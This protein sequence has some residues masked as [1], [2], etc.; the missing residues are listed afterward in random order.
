MKRLFSYFACILILLLLATSGCKKMDTNEELV[1]VEETIYEALDKEDK[2]LNKIE[3]ITEIEYME[4]DYFK[5]HFENYPEGVQENLYIIKST[6]VIKLLNILK[7][8]QFELVDKDEANDLSS[9]INIQFIRESATSLEVDIHGVSDYFLDGNKHIVNVDELKQLL[10]LFNLD[11]ILVYEKKTPKSLKDNEIYNLVVDGILGE[12]TD[13]SS[14]EEKNYYDYEIE[15]WHSEIMDTTEIALDIADYKHI[16]VLR[17]NIDQLIKYLAT[18]KEYLYAVEKNQDT[19]YLFYNKEN[20]LYYDSVIMNENYPFDEEN[21]SFTL[22]ETNKLGYKNAR[23]YKDFNNVA[24]HYQNN[25]KWFLDI[26]DRDLFRLDTIEVP[27]NYELVSLA[28]K[29]IQGTFYYSITGYLDGL[30]T[31]YIPC[32]YTNYASDYI[33]MSFIDVQD[34]QYKLFKNGIE[35]SGQ[36]LYPDNGMT[37]TSY[38]LV[39][40]KGFIRYSNNKSIASFVFETETNKQLA[41]VSNWKQIGNLI[42]FSEENYEKTILNNKGE[43]LENHPLTNKNIVLKS[44][45]LDS[46]GHWNFLDGFSQEIVQLGQD[47]EEMNRI[48]IPNEYL[49]IKKYF[50]ENINRYFEPLENGF[51]LLGDDVMI[52]YSYITDEFINIPINIRDNVRLH[53]GAV[54][55]MDGRT[56]KFNEE[57]FAFEIEFIND[58]EG[59]YPVYGSASFIFDSYGYYMDNPIFVSEIEEELVNNPLF[60]PMSELPEIRYND[61]TVSIT[62]TK[63][64][65]GKDLVKLSEN[66]F[67]GFVENNIF[68]PVILT[69]VRQYD[70]SSKGILYT[71]YEESQYAYFYDFDTN[72]THELYSN[73]PCE[74]LTLIDSYAYIVV[75]G[76]Y[77]MNIDINESISQMKTVTINE[78]ELLEFNEDSRNRAFYLCDNESEIAVYSRSYSDSL[79]FIFDTELKTLIDESKLKFHR[80][81]EESAILSA[82]GYIVSRD[83]E[84]GKDHIINY[85]LLFGINLYYE[86]YI[87]NNRAYEGPGRTYIIHEDDL[88]T[89]LFKENV[90]YTLE[91]GKGFSTFMIL[92][93]HIENRVT[94][95]GVYPADITY[96]VEDDILYYK[97]YDEKEF[98]QFYLRPNSI[99]HAY[100]D[101]RT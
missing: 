59:Y 27:A 26:M 5:V 16:D 13:V 37:G 3:N 1:L 76:S 82:L 35:M 9:I 81:T 86:G 12:V 70:V 90:D 30:K 39:L 69:D 29:S 46:K 24:I 91:I 31:Y 2:K 96:K 42:V 19:A 92:I 83:L 52:Y 68:I 89:D 32:N 40:N 79:T 100:R 61:K 54:Y 57:T 38:D 50:L 63:Q 73:E 75:K 49:T 71:G 64:V 101:K 45:K 18:S 17:L 95:L 85:D 15:Q 20:E 94:L 65:E 7:T 77:I 43:N 4:S 60:K 28:N 62:G 21:L 93:D 36:G 34:S 11:D 98:Q 44:L 14:D 66:G 41:T 58:F 99:I 87:I 67:L 25:D 48:Y 47:F 78:I 74:A 55:L 72:E 22:F 6:E 80:L 23:V 53:N 84:I 33:A 97:S 10:S 51:V 8:L 56:L 88:A